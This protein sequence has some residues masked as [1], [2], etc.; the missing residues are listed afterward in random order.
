MAAGFG[1]YVV[2]VDESGDHSLKSVDQDYPVFVLAFCV[3]KISDYVSSVVPALQAFKFRHFGHDMVV[4]HERE[5]RL[6]S[7]PFTS[8][9]DA[10]YREAFLNELGEAIRSIDCEV[11]SC[12][13]DK[14]NLDIF[15]REHTNAYNMAMKLGVSKL[16]DHMRTVQQ[17]E[18]STGLIVESRGKVEDRQLEL[19]FLKITKSLV[20][21]K[22]NLPFRMLFA[23]KQVNSTGLQIADLVARPIG[24]HFLKPD[25]SNRAYEVIKTK[26]ISET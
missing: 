5:I 4:L 13:I 20:G 21:P 12:V 24:I 25:D 9:V 8:L 18:L 23:N 3:F 14:R 6:S 19:E 22:G 11:I 10:E 2:Y 16:L 17:H 26:L 15:N 1:N 7:G